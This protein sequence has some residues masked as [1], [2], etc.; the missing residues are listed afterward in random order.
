[1]TKKP[2]NIKINYIGSDILGNV[3]T[4]KQCISFITAVHREFILL[5]RRTAEILY[6]TKIY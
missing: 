2:M 3:Q 1:M 6:M 5:D 4:G